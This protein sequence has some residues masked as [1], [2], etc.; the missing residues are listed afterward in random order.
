MT[1]ETITKELTF[2]L[3]ALKERTEKEIL[4]RYLKK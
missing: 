3:S 2:I 4:I 1:C